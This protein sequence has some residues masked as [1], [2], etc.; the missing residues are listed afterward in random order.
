MI[1]AS[2]RSKGFGAILVVMIVVVQ[3]DTLG[4]VEA[5]SGHVLIEV[6]L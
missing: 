2:G 3:P 1:S 6:R 4:V 5:G